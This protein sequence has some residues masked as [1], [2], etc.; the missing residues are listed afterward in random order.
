MF[1]KGHACACCTSHCCGPHQRQSSVAVSGLKLA[2]TFLD[3]LEKTGI[4]HSSVTMT[5]SPAGKERL[6]MCRP[7]AAGARPCTCTR[8][9]SRHV[10]MPTAQPAPLAALTCHDARHLCLGTVRIKGAGRL[11]SRPMQS[12]STPH[13]P[14]MH[15][16]CLPQAGTMRSIG[17]GSLRPGLRCLTPQSC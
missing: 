6:R 11:R 13:R 7:D 5:V 17:A 16:R 3:M 10:P 2:I 4:S 8:V 1:A 15:S 9:V 12:V 14:A